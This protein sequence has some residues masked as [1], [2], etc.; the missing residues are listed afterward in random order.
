MAGV[1][2]FFVFLYYVSVDRDRI[3]WCTVRQR[4]VGDGMTQRRKEIRQS[5]PPPYRDTHTRP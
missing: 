3:D 1:F 5:L 4:K 2:L